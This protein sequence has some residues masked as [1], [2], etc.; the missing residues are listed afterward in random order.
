M[1][2]TCI[3]CMVTTRGRTP[4]WAMEP[5]WRQGRHRIQAVEAAD[6]QQCCV[7]YEL[8]CDR[9][10]QRGVP[11]PSQPALGHGKGKLEQRV[12]KLQDGARSHSNHI[13]GDSPCRRL[14]LH[15]PQPRTSIDCSYSNAGCRHGRLTYPSPPQRPGPHYVAPDSTQPLHFTPN[16]MGGVRA[17]QHAP[18]TSC[19]ACRSYAAYRPGR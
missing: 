13:L 11:V 9:G 18:S 2:G 4:G 12:T 1:P 6:H 7:C 15:F 19:A 5:G 8:C 17:H 16:G 3:E 10:L 14:A